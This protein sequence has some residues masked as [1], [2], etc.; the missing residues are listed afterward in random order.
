MIE[1]M[2]DQKDGHDSDCSHVIRLVNPMYVY[3]LNSPICR[4]LTS[5]V[6]RHCTF[7]PTCSVRVEP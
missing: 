7:R 2:I 4:S 6:V 5:F 1:L 3:V